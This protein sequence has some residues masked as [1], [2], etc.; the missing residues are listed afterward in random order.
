MRPLLALVTFLVPAAALAEEDRIATDRP[1]FVE[2]ASVVGKGVFQIE[3]SVAA[4]R[5]R[6]DGV[7]T[8]TWTTPTLLR[9][10]VSDTL[11]LRLETEGFTWEEVDR[12]TTSDSENGFSNS[13]LGVKWQ[14]REGDEAAG[15][16]SVVWLAHLEMNS[17]SAAF[18]G[19]GTVPSLRMVAEWQL[20]D[21]AA[22]GVMPGLAWQKDDSGA[23]Y[24]AGILAATYSRP[25]GPSLRGF[26]ELAGRELR[27]ER[28]GGNQ[29]TFDTGLIYA[30]GDDAQIDAAINLGLNRSTPDVL[31]TAG[32]SIR[33][34]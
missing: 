16:P 25:L 15:T 24:W 3:T 18:R 12:G 5:D 10:G 32:F 14:M 11:E 28:H 33:F 6:R 30:I 21:D 4:E 22:F 2:A 23:R 7:T 29:L 27:S 9:L 13:A 19:S 20:P 8:R 1:D 34:R 31:A 26:V 17:G